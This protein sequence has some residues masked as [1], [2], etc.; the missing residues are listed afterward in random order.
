MSPNIR[1]ISQEEITKEIIKAL[2]LANTN[3]KKIIAEILNKLNLKIF[4]DIPYRSIDFTSESLCKCILFMEL[5]GLNQQNLEIYLKTHKN[6]RKKLGLKRTPDQT[7]ISNFIRTKIDE[8]ILRIINLTVKKIEE[9][10][11]KKDIVLDSIK[12]KRKTN[13]KKG[14]NKAKHYLKKRMTHEVSKLFKRRILPF[15][16]L[17]IKHNCIYNERIMVTLFLH[18]AK[19]NE[20]AENG[21]DTLRIALKKEKFQCPKCKSFLY[22]KDEFSDDC[23][24]ENKFVCLKCDYEK[25]ISPLGATFRYRLKRWKSPSE[26]LD[27]FSRIFEV[28]WQMTPESKALKRPDV[29]AGFDTTEWL[30]YGK[31]DNKYI[32]GKKEDRG[33]TWCYRFMT[34]NIV[35][36]GKRYTLYT[37]PKT[38]FDSQQDLLKKLI[39]FA[40]AH[41][42]IKLAL[43]DRGFFNTESQKL[44]QSY[45]IHYIMLIR[46]DSNIK[47]ILK[48]NPIPFILN[49]CVM[50]GEVSYNMAA[51]ERLKKGK[52]VIYAY[53]TNIPLDGTDMEKEANWIASEYS[54]RWGIETSYRT[55]KQSY[56]PKTSSKDY[57]IRLFYFFFAVLLYNMWILADVLVCLEINGKV[58]SKHLVTANFFRSSFFYIDPGG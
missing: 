13:K 41:V 51:V 34:I 33:T 53:A 48:V 42:R 12:I 4:L 25:R 43:L 44:L 40:R 29:I 45:G 16:D 14:K 30:Y 37:L 23:E 49:G 5:K 3:K 31:R 6:E 8:E 57:R 28:L 58:E 54:R 17:K 55:K 38:Q 2:L 36:A 39:E 21:A 20:F 22:P 7:N 15:I 35:Q 24:D 26:I 50:K 32:V 52:K 18:I 11:G 56:L 10:A 46:K 47:E 9:H 1:D 27:N 19:E